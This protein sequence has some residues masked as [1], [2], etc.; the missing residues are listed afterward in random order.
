MADEFNPE[1]ID[2]DGDGIVQEGTEFERPVEE[3]AVDPTVVVDDKPEEAPAIE[4]DISF[5]VS[6]EE[7]KTSAKPKTAKPAL[8]PV[9]DGVIGTGVSTAKPKAKRVVETASKRVAVHSSKNVSWNGVG[10]IYRGINI[11][12]AEEAEKWLTRDHVREA[13]KEE[14][15]EVAGI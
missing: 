1:A 9:A 14:V 12:S 2:G 7:P 10:R 8:A 6:S 3:L 4:E 5:V 11:L 15:A 13:T